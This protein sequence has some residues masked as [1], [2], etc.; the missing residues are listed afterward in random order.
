[1]KTCNQSFTFI[2]KEK[3]KF[4]ML[5]HSGRLLILIPN[6]QDIK[7]P[8]YHF[9]QNIKRTFEF[10]LFLTFITTKVWTTVQNICGWLLLLSLW[11]LLLF[12]SNVLVKYPLVIFR[13]DSIVCIMTSITID[14]KNSG[15]KNEVDNLNDSWYYRREIW[16]FYHIEFH[17]GHTNQK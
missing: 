1:M 13:C 5:R 2:K 12:I 6:V 11:Y 17:N 15:I 16:K 7:V 9:S 14:S 8:S 10:Y 3:D 4:G